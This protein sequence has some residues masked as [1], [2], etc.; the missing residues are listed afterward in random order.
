M[1]DKTPDGSLRLLPP[2]LVLMKECYVRE[3]STAGIPLIEI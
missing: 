2:T 1:V 3:V